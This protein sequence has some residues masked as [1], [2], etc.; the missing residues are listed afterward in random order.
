MRGAAL[1]IR[2]VVGGLV[3]GLVAEF[4]VALGCGLLSDYAGPALLYDRFFEAFHWP[5]YWV[6]TNLLPSKLLAGA[7]PGNVMLVCG[8]IQFAVLAWLTLTIHKWSNRRRRE[9]TGSQS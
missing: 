9:N 1:R 5:G 2:S 8:V 4:L 6:A 7:W 3:F